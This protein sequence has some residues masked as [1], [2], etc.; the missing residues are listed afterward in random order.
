MSPLKSFVLEHV[1]PDEYYA[2]RFPQWNARSRELVS[3][4]FH[5]DGS[6]PNLSVGLRNGGAHCHSGRCGKR[7]GNIVHF[8]SERRSISE[9]LATRYL[10]NEFVRPII[11]KKTV[12]NFRENLF[13]EPS[14]LIAIRKQMGLTSKWIRKFN[15]G[16]DPKSNR[17]TI[18]VYDQFNQCIN[19]RFYR[20]PRERTSNDNAKIHNYKKG[21]GS[22]DLFSWPEISQ[23]KINEPILLLASEKET[24]LAR[25]LGWAAL[26]STAGEG[27]WDD[28]WNSIIENRDVVVVFDTDEAGVTAGTKITKKLATVT[29]SIFNLQLS[30]RSKRTDWKDFADWMLREHHTPAEFRRL[31]ER[32]LASINRVDR[33]RIPNR[34]KDRIVSNSS[35][36]VK[37][38]EKPKLPKLYDKQHHEIVEI[39]S[40]SELLNH[41][42]RASGIVAAKSPNTFSIPWKFAIQVKGRNAF[43]QTLDVGRDLLRFVRASDSAIIS[44]I[45][46]IIGSTQAEIEP[47]EYVTIT[48]VEIIPTAVADKDV[49]YVIQR[50]FYVGERIEANIPY[51]LELIPVAEVRSQET[52]GIIVDCIPLS[53]SIDRFIFN[54]EVFANLSIFQPTE[55][56]GVWDKLATI[57]NEIASRFTRVYNR[58]DWTIAALLT[59]CSP[60]GFRF[61]GEPELQRG[62]LNTLALGDTET[63]KSKVAK[64]LQKIFNCGVFVSGENCTF[65]G[66]VGGAIKGSG[67]RLMLRWGRIPLSDKQL[68]ILEELSGLS[69]RE[70]SDMSDVRSSG[71]ARLDKGGINSETNS[72]T[73][74]LCLSNARSERRPLSGHLFGVHAVHELIGHGEDIARFDLITTLTDREVSTN[75]INASSFALITNDNE[76]ATDQ[77]QQLVHWVWSL[78]PDQVIIT[79]EAYEACLKETKSLAIIYHPSIPIFKG[80]SGR[81]KLARV[82]S[83]IA[84]LQFSCDNTGRLIVN[85]EHVSAARTLLE[86]TYRKPSLGYFEYSKQMY[87]RE[88]VK[89]EKLLRQ[90]FRKAIPKERLAKVLDTL[91]H[92]TRFSRDELQAI[93]GIGNISA[94]KLI[95]TMLRE[96]VLKKGDANLWDITPAGKVW[97]EKYIDRIVNQV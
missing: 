32:S 28:S 29:K 86:L 1:N 21:Y 45:Q 42:I 85:A 2:A 80:G 67:D 89:D 3:C 33:S 27:S 88:T 14:Y 65:V 97:M 47:L 30:F 83:A 13:C 17:I 18:P 58:L 82:A 22:L 44:S 15:L 6:T 10:Y 74:L 51:Q 5:S 94:D 40:R 4:C 46:S 81:Y 37:E 75:I 53:R 24:M 39:S 77:L 7:L 9:K 50:C 16:L 78:T 19:I 49:P 36:S 43:I 11:S 90:E 61:P 72:R 31:V 84:A 71:V 26:C 92:S 69:V 38:I 66:L 12:A 52:I 73:R 57:A 34:S 55:G 20:L 63:G 54:P 62:W 25:S 35:P 64:A 41:R 68:V 56:E 23:F 59:W 95:G 93:G 96:R 60:I 70:I 79:Q 87:D 48:E 76:I 8:E 91:I